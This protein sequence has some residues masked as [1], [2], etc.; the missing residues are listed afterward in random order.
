MNRKP[1]RKV[2]GG[3]DQEAIDRR[4]HARHQPDQ[5]RTPELHQSLFAPQAAHQP[6]TSTRLEASRVTTHPGR[7]ATLHRMT[8]RLPDRVIPED[9]ICQ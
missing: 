4:R 1:L 6:I 8:A 7:H 5:S 9:S 2:L 3:H